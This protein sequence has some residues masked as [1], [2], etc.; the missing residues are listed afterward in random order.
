MHNKYLILIQLNEINFDLALR[1]AEKYNL[2]NL[3]KLLLLK[4]KNYKTSSENKYNLLEPWIQWVSVYTGKSANEH[5]IFRLGDI[6][7]Y[8]QD[9]LYRK[10]EKLKFKIGAIAPMNA[11]N[12][13]ENPEYFIPDPWTNTK[14]D[15]SKWSIKITNLINTTVNNNTKKI[16]SLKIIFD[17]IIIFF[18]FSKIK[19]YN[20]YFFYLFTSFKNKWRKALFLDLLL[21]DIHLHYLEKYKPNFSSIFFN[22]G[23]HIQHHYLLRSEFIENKNSYNKIDPIYDSLYLY[24]NIL[25]QYIHNNKYEF[26][27]HTGLTQE[28]NSEAS[29]YYRLKDHR[30]F[31]TFFDIDFKNI[32]PR[33]SRDF[34]I[35]FENQEQTIVAAELIKNIRTKDVFNERIFKTIDIRN[36]SIFVTLTYPKK[37]DKKLNIYS[38]NKII[39]FN[40]CVDF[41]AVKNGV[42]SPIGYLF[43]SKKLKKLVGYNQINIKDIY[44]IILEYFS[45]EIK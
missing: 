33:M 28:V 9:L 10:L 1:Y 32:Q 41:V 12:D 25:S 30:E 44:N 19:N 26:I 31:V 39:N 6:V 37:I 34:L 27:I 40:K 23:A 3:K 5:K 38:N 15:D 29:Y 8:E 24:D 35:E 4:S 45:N 13:L 18:K 16:F 21:N 36:K 17:L 2:S 20:L 42:H 14:C 43:T 11:K 7:N 22:A